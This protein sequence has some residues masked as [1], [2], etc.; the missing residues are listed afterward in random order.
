V[1]EKL[2]PKFDNQQALPYGGEVGVTY[3]KKYGQIPHK[4]ML[5]FMR[6]KRVGRAVHSD[7]FLAL[8]G[9]VE[10]AYT[11]ECGFNGMFLDVKCA[12]CGKDLGRDKSYQEATTD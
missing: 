5:S 11:C 12:R 1:I 7:G 9:L 4:D 6:E 2:E 3:S 8:G 10:P